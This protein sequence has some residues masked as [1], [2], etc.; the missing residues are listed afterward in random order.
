MATSEKTDSKRRTKRAAD[1]P[2]CIARC[3]EILTH[4][5]RLFAE[6]GYDKTDTT[7]AGRIRWRR[8]GDHLP[9]LPK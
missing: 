1:D 8:E 6:L 5:A 7:A 3:E 9:L 2:Q 4:A